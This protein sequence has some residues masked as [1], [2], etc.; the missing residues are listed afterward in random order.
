VRARFQ[1]TSTHKVDAKGRVSIPADFRRV[2]DATDPDRE[3]GTNPSVILLFGDRRN[4]WFDCY[5]IQG[6]SEI[7]ALIEDMDEGDPDR[8]ALEEHF[9]AFSETI[10][11]DDSGRLVLSKALR[12]MIGVEADLTFQARGKTFRMFSPDAP[13]EVTSRLNA[14]LSELPADVP[15]TA[16]LRAKRRREA[17][18]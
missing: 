18:L 14:A 6:M 3:P 13:A 12:D 15:V 7:D 17:A 11:I 10:R 4:P 5:T 8:L 1:G 16:L 9:Y 2:L